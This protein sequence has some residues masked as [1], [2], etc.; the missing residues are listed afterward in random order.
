MG[1]HKLTY[2]SSASLY[3]LPLPVY[4]ELPLV[5]MGRKGWASGFPLPLHHQENVQGWISNVCHGL[6]SED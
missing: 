3:L 2:P 1:A 5:Y 4:L 6:S